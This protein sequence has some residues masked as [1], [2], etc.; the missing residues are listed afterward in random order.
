MSWS[1]KAPVNAGETWWKK[2]CFPRLVRSHCLNYVTISFCWYSAIGYGQGCL[3]KVS[4]ASEWQVWLGQWKPCLFLHVCTVMCATYA[5]RVQVHTCHLSLEACNLS[6][7]HMYQL[8][9]IIHIW[10]AAKHNGITVIFGEI[11]N[12]GKLASWANIK[13]RT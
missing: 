8:W 6:F 13:H 10:V 1:G 7:T 12:N 5:K 11:S 9:K 4:I 3:Q 2:A